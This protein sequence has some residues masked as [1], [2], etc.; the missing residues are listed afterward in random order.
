MNRAEFTE[1]HLIRCTVLI[2]CLGQNNELL[3][4]R[5]FSTIIQPTK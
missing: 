4:Q 1:H 3:E 5:L 2:C